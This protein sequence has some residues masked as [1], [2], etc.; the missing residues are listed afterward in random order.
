MTCYF[1]GVALD[2]MRVILTWHL[3]RTTSSSCFEV[4]TES[5]ATV[6]VVFSRMA[7]PNETGQ[8]SEQP[9]VTSSTPALPVPETSEAHVPAEGNQLEA[10]TDVR[11]CVAWPR[12]SRVDSFA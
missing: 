11:S 6:V 8:P 12:W 5:E 1:Q 10:D 2:E 4:C 3:L 7:T 9:A